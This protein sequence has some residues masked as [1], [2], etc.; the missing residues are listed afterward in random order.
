MIKEGGYVYVHKVYSNDESR[1]LRKGVYKIEE[2][3]PNKKVVYVD[4][5]LKDK[6]YRLMLLSSQYNKVLP[7]KI[8]KLLYKGL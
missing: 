3:Y 7:N 8:N 1:G 5:Y 2:V 6:V 4:C